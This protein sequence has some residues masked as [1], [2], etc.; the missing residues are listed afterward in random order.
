MRCCQMLQTPCLK[1][2][3]QVLLKVVNSQIGIL[4]S[5]PFTK[6]MYEITFCQLS[7]LMAK[8]LTDSDFFQFYSYKIK[9]KLHI[10]WDL[11]TFNIY[12]TLR[13]SHPHSKVDRVSKGNSI[14][15]G[16]FLFGP[17]SRHVQNHYFQPFTI[18]L[19]VDNQWFGRFF[20]GWSKIENVFWDAV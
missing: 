5:I 12:T 19:K 15:E 10:Y 16:F 13:P 8:K 14:S 2:S 6:K 3:Q 17:I 9:I 7:N 4:I 20:W 1:T 11:A 18:N